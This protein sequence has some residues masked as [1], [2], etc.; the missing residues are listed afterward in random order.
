MF[1]AAAPRAALVI[2]MAN[3]RIRDHLER[4]QTG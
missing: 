4:S 2:L 3:G 1:V